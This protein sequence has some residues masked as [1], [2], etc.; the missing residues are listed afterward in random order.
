LNSRTQ[1]LKP[2]TATTT[3]KYRK[4]NNQIQQ[5]RQRG[6]KATNSYKCGGC[7]IGKLGGF[8]KK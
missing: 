2:K 4:L 7:I 8:G 6:I 5:Q 1:K 3:R